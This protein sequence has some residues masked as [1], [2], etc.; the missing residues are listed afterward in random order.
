MDMIVDMAKVMPKGQITI[1]KE[2]RD[3]LGVAPGD[4]VMVIWDGER[5]SMMNPAIYAMQWLSKELEGE[6]E[7]IGLGTEEEIIAFCK[8]IRKEVGDRKRNANLD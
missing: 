4:K 5:V 3:K 6:A 2:I 7:K 1:P 8:E